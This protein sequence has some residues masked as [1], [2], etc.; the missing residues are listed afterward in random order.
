MS[1]KPPTVIVKKFN[2]I[3]EKTYDVE[4]D[5]EEGFIEWYEKTNNKKF[6][7]NNFKAEFIYAMAKG[8]INP[9]NIIK[10]NEGDSLDKKE[11]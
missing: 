1:D 8:I 5:F 7:L 9:D 2:K 10:E 11:D 3:D 4:F 6:D